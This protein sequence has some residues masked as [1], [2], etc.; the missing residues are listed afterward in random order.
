[1][2]LDSDS[3]QVCGVIAWGAAGGFRVGHDD[4]CSNNGVCSGNW[5][6]SSRVED[7]SGSK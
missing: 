3:G 1:M 2:S 6:V 7:M 5:Y 4:Y